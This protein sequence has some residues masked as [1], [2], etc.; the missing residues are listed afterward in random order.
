[1]PKHLVE[2]LFPNNEPSIPEQV[3]QRTTEIGQAVGSKAL[4]L[5]IR[6]FILPAVMMYEYLTE[7]QSGDQ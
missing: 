1:M 7:R 3:L 2:A 5:A 6:P 4:E